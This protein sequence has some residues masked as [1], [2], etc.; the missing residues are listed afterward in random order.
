MA[1]IVIIV[2]LL[3]QF[4]LGHVV[5]KTYRESSQKH[6]LL[7][8]AINGLETIK[9]A[10]AEGQIQRQWE[11]LVSLTA[12]SSGKARMISTFSTSFAQT[13]TQLTTVGVVIFGVFEIAAGNMTIG[14]LIASTILVGRAMAP[15]GRGC[16]D[17][18]QIPAIAQLRYKVSTP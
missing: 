16:C 7:I 1:P 8:E 10:G 13:A 9:A 14:A 5:S 17:A 18:D 12:S 3:M 11:K 2:G 15:L 6:S 4:P